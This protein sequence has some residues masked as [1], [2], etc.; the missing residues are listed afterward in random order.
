ML[1]H[2]QLMRDPKYN[3]YLDKS[4]STNVGSLAN[5]VSDRVKRTKT[6]AI[7]C[8]YN[9]PQSRMKDVTYGFFVCNVRNE[10][11]ENNQT[12]C[13][14][15]GVRINYTIEVLIPTADMLVAKLLFNSIISTKWA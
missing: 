10:K 12:R 13:V 1:N 7:S 2:R 14:V 9:I 6:I 5:V 11:T 3:I 4:A 8:K 15:G